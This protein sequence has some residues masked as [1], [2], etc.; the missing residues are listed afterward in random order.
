MI[1]T[2]RQNQ[3]W[4]PGPVKRYNFPF[5]GSNDVRKSSTYDGKY[6]V[7]TD[8][9][10]PDDK[11]QKAVVRQHTTQVLWNTVVQLIVAA[12]ASR[13]EL[14]YQR[15]RWDQEAAF[16]VTALLRAKRKTFSSESL[17]NILKHELHDD[18]VLY[19]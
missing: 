4:T 13:I 1:G 12:V 14:D 7:Q 16:A 11:K 19:I 3:L 10:W 9:T 15:L 5:I 17:E 18:A 2:V 8:V 6:V